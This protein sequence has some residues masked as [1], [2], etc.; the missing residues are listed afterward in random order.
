MNK[1][2]FKIVFIVLLFFL[3]PGFLITFFNAPNYSYGILVIFCVAIYNFILIKP[4]VIS[5]NFL[6]IVLISFLL[7]FFQLINHFFYIN[8]DIFKT[9]LMACTFPLIYL[10]SKKILYHLLNIK[11]FSFLVDI[12][13]YLILICLVFGLMYYR[14]GYVENTELRLF[15]FTE[16]SHIVAICGPIFVL[17]IFNIQNLKTILLRFLVISFLVLLTGSSSFMVFLVIVSFVFLNFKRLILIYATSIF[18]LFLIY[19]LEIQLFN[20]RVDLFY[21]RILDT[22]LSIGIENYSELNMSTVVFIQ[23]YEFIFDI[24][25]RYDF[26]GAGS[27]NGLTININY[28]AFKTIT[29]WGP[30]NRS[31]PGFMMS[32]VAMEYGLIFFTIYLSSYILFFFNFLRLRKLFIKLKYSR[33]DLL[34]VSFFITA[35]INAFIRGGGYLHHSMLYFFLCVA[36]LEYQHAIKK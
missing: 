27:G 25:H 16:P 14:R 29:A 33:I 15:F 22:Y 8:N 1:I 13:N 2:N 30:L 12:I 17:Y 24:F 4:I 9:F 31:D 7:I 11:N 6:I 32:K 10:I 23:G 19:S 18:I 21:D 3:F 28:P 5:N 36:I 26:L 35:F 20:Q 34:F